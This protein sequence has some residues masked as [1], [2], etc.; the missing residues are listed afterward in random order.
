MVWEN[1]MSRF[2]VETIDRPVPKVLSYL[3]EDLVRN[4]LDIWALTKERSR[5]DLKVCSLGN[6][7]KAHLGIYKTPEAQYTSLGGDTAAAKALLGYIPGK[8]VLTIPPTLAELV[9]TKVR[10]DAIY[11][12]DIMLVTRGEEELE[13]SGSVRRLGPSD[14]AQYSTFGSSFNVGEASK[15]WAKDRL[16]KNVIFGVFD[17]GKLVSVA[18]LAVWLPKTAV[19]LGVETKTEYRRKGF[20]RIVVSAAVREALRRSESCSLFVRSDNQEAISLYQKLGFKK[21]GEELWIDIGT[22]IVP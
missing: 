12:N 2:E 3:G 8:A 4:A 20:G 1:N 14:F 13:D 18:S 22:G 21:V 17:E 7:V 11:P 6:E 19:I 10:L 15:Q 5:Y 16:S 9:R